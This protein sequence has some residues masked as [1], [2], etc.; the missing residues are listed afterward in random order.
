MFLFVPSPPCSARDRRR[1]SCSG[2]SATCCSTRPPRSRRRCSP[3]R[4]ERLGWQN[5]W[6]QMVRVGVQQHPDRLAGPVLHRRD[7]RACR[8]RRS[9]RLRRPRQRGGHHLRRH[10]PRAGPAGQRDRAD[11]FRR[12]Q[13]RGG[14][15]H[16]GRLRRNRGAGS[17]RRSTRSGSWSCRGCI[18][19]TIM[20]VCL[21]VVGDL[22]GVARRAARRP[23]VS[24]ASASSQYL[25]HTF[26]AIEMQDFFTGLMKAGVFGA[27]ISGLACY[28]GLSVTGGAQGV[29]AATTRTVVLHDRRADHRGP[30]VHA[31]CFTTWGCDGDVRHDARSRVDESVLPKSSAHRLE[32]RCRHPSRRHKVFGIDGPDAINSTCFKG[33]RW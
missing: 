29:G 2:G 14:D 13:H 12:R 3:G 17:A 30:D 18:A 15:G 27:L 26:D 24:W 28:L 8:W 19:T 23:D 6:A 10:L 11:R 16:D 1:S 4:G 32:C 31:A 5:L 21:A 9:S 7:P 33:R 25:D 20:M 22:M